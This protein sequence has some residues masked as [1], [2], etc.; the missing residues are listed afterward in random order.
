M[1]PKSFMLI[2]GEPSGDALAAELVQAL[3]RELAEAQP[4]PTADYQ[5]L[6]TSLEPRFFGAGGPRMAAAGVELAFDLTA[7]SVI[8]LPIKK[9]FKLRPLF[10]RLYQLALARQPDVII[11][12]DYGEFNRRFAQAIR[13]Y[14]R[15]RQDWFHDWRPR[16]VQYSSPQVWASR[17]GRAYQIA[18][19]YDLL[20]SLFQFEKEWYAKRVPR[21]RVEFV[22]HPM[23]ERYMQ[24]RLPQGKLPGNHSAASPASAPS[25]PTIVLLPGSR[26]MELK[27]H[28]PV[29]LG[30]IQLLRAALPNLSA[31]MVLPD[32]ELAQ[33]AKAFGLPGDVEVQIGGLPEALTRADLALAKTGTVT[34]E[35]AYFGVPTVA[36]YKTSWATYQIGKRVVTVKYL[37]MP[38]LLANEA[39]FPEF[40]QGAATSKNLAG[41]ALELLRDENRRAS[42]KR[43]LA[44]ILGALGEPGASGR[45]A[46]AILRL[47]DQR[48]ALPQAT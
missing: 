32:E 45:A 44:E 37:A 35:C 31:R 27:R 38:N 16:L 3:R 26:A 19:D 29:I 20:L 21:F 5:P 12:V 18:R 10:H 9:Y 47:L 2:A 34:M 39:L 7:H 36:Y 24:K 15:P 42:I 23:V 43:R 33:R 6:H 1:K 14:V 40:I 48:L 11:C 25:G 41:A 17:K 28:L 13:R 4:V 30:A 22:G 8:G 46:R